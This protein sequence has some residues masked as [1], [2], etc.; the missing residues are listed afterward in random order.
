MECNQTGLLLVLLILVWLSS[1]RKSEVMKK[2]L[3]LFL[4]VIPSAI[5]AQSG[6][7]TAGDPY[8]GT[9]TSSVIWDPDTYP[10]STVYVGTASNNDL[11]IGSGGHLTIWPGTTIVFTQPTSDLAITGTGRIT[12][13]G[14]STNKITFTK[15]PLNASWGHMIFDGMTGTNSSLI[16]HC[17]FEYGRL[18][19]TTESY[20]NAGGG[21]CV[22][23]SYVT[24]QDCRF[25]NN[26]ALFGG[27]LFV[28]LSQSPTIR[29]CYFEDNTA[30]EAGGALY[31]YNNSSV[32]VENC[33]FDGN[34]AD[35]VTA[36]YYGGGAVQ[37]GI[38]TTNAKVINSTFVNNIADRSGNSVYFFSTGNVVNCIF[39]GSGNEIGYR[40]TGGTVTNCA[41]Q[42]YTPSSHNTECIN[43]NASNSASDGPN[44]IALDG[45]N[46][47]IKYI[48]PCR[49]I[50][51]ATGAPATDYV[52]KSRIGSP[53]IG[54]YEVQYSRWDG[55]AGTT[56][57]NAAN[58]EQ[59][60][61]PVSGSSDI[62][63]PGG[64]T[65]Y[66]ITSGTNFT[67]GNGKYMIVEP[68]GRVTFD[69]LTNSSGTLV[70]Q[71]DINA[72]AS[73]KFNSYTDS[74]TERIN[75]Y[76][77]GGGGPAYKWHYLA[78]P[79]SMNKSVFT[80]VDPYNLLLFDDSKIV[81]GNNMEG[82]QWHDG[83]DG[84]TSFNTLVTKKGY[85]FYHASDADV[86]IPAVSGLLST[87]GSSVPLQFN[88]NGLNLLGNSL[89]CSLNW[90]EV[91]T[92]GN[93][94]DAI[95]FTTNNSL[96]SYV[97]GVGTPL[98]TTGIIPPLQG[99][100]VKALEAGC[101]V[102]FSGV[103]VKTHGTVN[104]FK[105][106]TFISLLRLE[107]KREGLTNDEMVVRF[108]Y[109]ATTEFD[110][111][112]D[113]SKL[114]A[115]RAPK[116]QIWSTIDNEDYS[117]N[118][119]P[120]PDEEYILPLSLVIKSDGNHSI[121]RTQL[122]G[123][124]NY[125]IELIDTYSEYVTDLKEKDEYIFASASGSYSDRL[126]L[127][128]TSMAT[129]IGDIELADRLINIFTWNNTLNIQPLS[130]QWSNVKTDISV[131]DITGR[132]IKKYPGREL[133]IGSMIELPFNEPKGVYIVEISDGAKRQVQKIA[134]R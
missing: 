58:W 90:D 10:G 86:I 91:V 3:I 29:R 69:V 73:L 18:T 126:F 134:N 6:S 128:I 122:V 85:N 63:I 84:T 127:K 24:I 75:M 23:S 110:N 97:A 117:I 59:N 81:T 26:Y 114:F 125:T 31:I 124:E 36:S 35:G 102:N 17:I 93:M 99:F 25:R 55:S 53:D 43:L 56:W 88:G 112:F 80:N 98:G 131:Y 51:T 13:S 46:W 19:G 115:D 20:A 87:M 57:T 116:A 95:Y 71:S 32:V 107:L 118:A 104:R 76:L 113:A 108:D 103:N 28:G 37:F 79:G 9:I 1:K 66:P 48:S 47:S 89:T 40:S 11:T 54:A 64:L 129:G 77:T 130:D 14:Q 16:Q 8:Y 92:S 39:W 12:A 83:Y 45:T 44:F 27:G 21:I 109:D 106:E 111:H 133:Y 123:L 5:F 22:N 41:I 60:I 61:S 15:A 68:G 82:W 101:S 42:G 119:I 94:R 4:L 34:Y 120:F 121:K 96:V 67:I 65:Y 49:D 105:S 38:N 50:G 78:V 70:L 52:L 7:G 72:I 30:R 100:F 132:L 33:I 2:I 62:V 74:G